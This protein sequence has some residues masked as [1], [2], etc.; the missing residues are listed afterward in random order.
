MPA[1]RRDRDEVAEAETHA[2]SGARSAGAGRC[3][4]AAGPPARITNYFI[5]FSA[6]LCIFQTFSGDHTGLLSR[7]GKPAGPGSGVRVD[8][9]S[10]GTTPNPPTAAPRSQAVVMREK[11]SSPCLFGANTLARSQVG[12][13]IKRRLTNQTVN[14]TWLRVGGP[15]VGEGGAR[16]E[17]GGGGA[18]AVWGQSRDGA[19]S[20]LGR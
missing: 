5:L 10:L 13:K 3:R 6:L 17:S 8:G 14:G 12:E 9:R 1:E 20:P 15:G 19:G 4:G 18:E 11:R 16:T 2:P 7:T